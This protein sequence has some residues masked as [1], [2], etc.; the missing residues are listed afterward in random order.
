MFNLIKSS[1]STLKSIRL[2][3]LWERS[4]TIEERSGRKKKERI[5]GLQLSNLEDLVVSQSPAFSLDLIDGSK[6]FKLK[7]I[8]YECTEKNPFVE[9]KSKDE[10]ASLSSLLSIFKSARSTL[11]SVDLNGLSFKVGVNCRR[12]AIAMEGYRILNLKTLNLRYLYPIEVTRRI[13]GLRYPSLQDC[14]FDTFFHTGINSFSFPHFAHF[15]KKHRKTLRRL[16]LQGGGRGARERLGGYETLG[17]YSYTFKNIEKIHIGRVPSKVWK[18]L[19][20]FR[21]PN[22]VKRTKSKSL[23]SF[24]QATKGGGRLQSEEPRLF[25]RIGGLD[26]SESESESDSDAE[27]DETE[28]ELSLIMYDRS[29]LYHLM[30]AAE[31]FEGW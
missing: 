19:L 30:R 16:S 21:Y 29:F 10:Q 13:T 25:M 20:E 23:K 5:D 7:T 11:E 6:C 26:E 24:K 1:Q 12:Q 2:E 15:I 9:R 31:R 3:R 14:S 4:E 27:D 8:R 22:L 17:D 28:M 18:F